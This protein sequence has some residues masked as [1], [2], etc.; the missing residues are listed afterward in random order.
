MPEQASFSWRILT[1]V[2]LLVVGLVSL[3]VGLWFFLLD[4][5]GISIIL[6]GTCSIGLAMLLG[7]IK[8]QSSATHE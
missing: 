2:C 5:S 1:I 6:F 7:W 3:E 4:H 8:S